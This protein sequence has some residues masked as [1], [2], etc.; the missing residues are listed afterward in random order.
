M[1]GD[2]TRPMTSW[3][4]THSSYVA[5]STHAPKFLYRI[6]TTSKARK[7]AKGEGESESERERERET[8]AGERGQKHLQ[9]SVGR[10]STNLYT[11]LASWI[12]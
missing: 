11:S 2:A 9:G 4:N 10:H 8:G 6:R 5:A 7:E 3:F 12:L 1:L